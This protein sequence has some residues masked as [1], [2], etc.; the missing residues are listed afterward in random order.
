AMLT[1][2]FADGAAD[3]ARVNV[4]V[5]PWVTDRLAGVAVMDGVVLAVSVAVTVAAGEPVPPAGN[6]VV[7]VP[8][9]FAITG[10]VCAV[11][12]FG[13]VNVSVAGDAVSPAL[14]D[15]A[16]VTVSLEVGAADS[17]SVNV[18]VLPWVT[19]KADGVALIVGV[20]VPPAGVHVTLVGATL[21]PE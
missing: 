5:P 12:K 13:G 16:M 18:P 17:A 10:T 9:L 6:V 2:S 1:V 11:A 7:P 4:P 8:V 20:V 14:P 15:A 19:D 21:L 3:S